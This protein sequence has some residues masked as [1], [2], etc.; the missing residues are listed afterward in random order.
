M[1]NRLGNIPENMW[2]RNGIAMGLQWDCN[3][4]AM[5]LNLGGITIIS[6][7]GG[8]TKGDTRTKIQS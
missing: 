6:D 2:D 8:I 7:Y 1:I 5:G 4:I 3:G